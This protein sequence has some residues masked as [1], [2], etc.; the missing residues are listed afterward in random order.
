MADLALVRY[1]VR[2]VTRIS[3]TVLMMVI[4]ASACDK[5]DAGWQAVR[6][7]LKQQAGAACGWHIAIR[8]DRP[9]REPR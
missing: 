6:A 9:K 8:H 2:V 5:F 7:E 1:R 4:V 3:Y